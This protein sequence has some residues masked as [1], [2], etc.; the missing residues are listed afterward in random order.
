VLDIAA[1][2]IGKF[3]F[4]DYGFDFY[5]PQS[6]VDERGR[7]ISFAWM[8]QPGTSY[9]TKPTFPEKYRTERQCPLSH[10][11]EIRVLID[12]SAVEVF[13]NGGLRNFATRWFPLNNVLTVK[14]QS[15]YEGMMA[16]AMGDGMADVWGAKEVAQKAAAGIQGQ[17]LPP[18]LQ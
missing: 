11:D 1:V 17:D 13:F 2:D 16:W 10:A 8:G 14:L 6:F 3:T 12:G 9:I 4:W 18:Y 5:A 15:R 7:T